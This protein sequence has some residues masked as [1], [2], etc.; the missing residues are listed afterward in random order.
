MHGCVPGGGGMVTPGIDSC[1]I[2]SPCLGSAVLALPLVPRFTKKYLNGAVL[3]GI[4]RYR[5]AYCD[6]RRKSFCP[7]VFSRLYWEIISIKL[8]IL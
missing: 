5:R 2:C 7:R 8:S 1:V 3:A 4:A 6:R